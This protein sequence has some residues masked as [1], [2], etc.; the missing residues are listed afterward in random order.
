MMTI[1]R[2]HR[3]RQPRSNRTTNLLLA[4]TVLVF[5]LIA[6]TAVDQ[7][8]RQIVAGDTEDRIQRDMFQALVPRFL[9]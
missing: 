7:Q 6:D 5:A 1:M 4:T 2:L 9:F 8:D 3:L